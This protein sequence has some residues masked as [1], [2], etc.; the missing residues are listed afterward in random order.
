MAV[1]ARACGTPMGSVSLVD[2]ER[3]W[4]KAALGVPAAEGAR[5]LSFCGHAILDPS[6]LMV[7]NDARLDPRF[8]DNPRVLGEPH[9]RFYAGAPLIAASGHVETTNTYSKKP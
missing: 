8:H 9:I 6:R 1:P 3:E 7:V 5:D 4:Y 2:A